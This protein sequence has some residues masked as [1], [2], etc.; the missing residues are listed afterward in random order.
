[1]EQVGARSKMAIISPASASAVS[2]GARRICRLAAP[3]ACFADDCLANFFDRSFG[4]GFNGAFDVFESV[5]F[6][7]GAAFVCLAFVA[8]AGRIVEE[9]ID[10]A[11]CGGDFTDLQRIF[12]HAFKGGHESFHVGDFA[13]HQELQSVLGAGVVAEVDEAFIDNFGAGFGGDVAAEVNVEFAGDLE[14][15]SGPRV[16]HGVAKRDATAAG[17]GNEWIGFGG[18]A[19]GFHRLEMHPRE[20]ADDFQM[21]EFLGADVHEE[22]FAGHVGAIE[23]LN[24]I[25]HGGGEFAVGPAELLEKHVAETRIGFADANGVHEFFNVMIHIFEK[26]SCW[27]VRCGEE[28]RNEA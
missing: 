13:R 11:G 27:T 25:L 22:I 19:A 24:G 3:F 10:D 4:N 23:S 14:V 15:I 21:A 2:F 12:S 28:S 9:L 16:A 6:V 8:F 20:G 5:A 1:M 26:I 17:D 18:L 7:P